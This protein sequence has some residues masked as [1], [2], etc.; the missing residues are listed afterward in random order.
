MSRYGMAVLLAA[1]VWIGTASA[2]AVT[3]Q[4]PPVL[5]SHGVY[6]SAQARRGAS[7]YE[8]ICLA[9]HTLSRFRGADFA[10]KWSSQPLA[11]LY[12]AVKA[13][14]LGEPESLASEEYADV[15]A[16]L[17]SINGYPAGQHEL[18]G[19]DAA[20]AAVTLDAKAP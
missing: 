7:L 17:L 3:V 19:S 12:K 13:M 1:A 20:M 14:P 18:T 11:V 2:H 15:V 9:C 16:Y 4:V 10:T 8:D 5:A 6:T